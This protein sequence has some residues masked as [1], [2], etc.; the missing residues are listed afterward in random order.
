LIRPP[1]E[2]LEAP[3]EPQ[4]WIDEQVSPGGVG[5]AS[6][7]LPVLAVLAFPLVYIAVA[8]Q[9][10]RAWR[11][12]KSPGLRLLYVLAIHVIGVALGFGALLLIASALKD[13]DATRFGSAAAR[14]LIVAI[15]TVIF[16]LIAAFAH[17]TKHGRDGDAKGSI[18]PLGRDALFGSYVAVTSDP[19]KAELRRREEG[20]LAAQELEAAR[21]K[22]DAVRSE[23]LVLAS[24]PSPSGTPT[25]WSTEALRTEI[26]RRDRLESLEREY[27]RLIGDAE[28]LARKESADAASGT[29]PA[30]RR[31]TPRDGLERREE[32]AENRRR[33]AEIEEWNRR[34]RES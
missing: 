18:K 25:S 23:M 21:R 5:Y 6:L 16:S 14:G 34:Q 22:A 28:K 4:R 13:K 17:W 30:P 8:L 19:L 24:Q 12:T 26:A 32:E 2:R 10:P 20:E 1:I 7:V 9:G 31:T 3:S 27:A 33:L 29:S 11:W 15:S